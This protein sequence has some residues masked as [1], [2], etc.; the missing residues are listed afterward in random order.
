MC[1]KV[2]NYHFFAT[3]AA[4]IDVQV[5]GA[6]VR[7]KEKINRYKIYAEHVSV[8]VVCVHKYLLDSNVHTFMHKF[9]PCR[10]YSLSISPSQITFGMLEFGVDVCMKYIYI[11]LSS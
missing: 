5:I 6:C 7:W 9:S 1:A 10:T 11:T 8:M 3:T 2:K 4:I